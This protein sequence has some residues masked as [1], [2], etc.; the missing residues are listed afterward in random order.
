MALSVTAAWDDNGTMEFA[1]SFIVAT[2][3]TFFMYGYTAL[4]EKRTKNPQWNLLMQ[5][6]SLIPWI[7][8]AGIQQYF[9]YLWTAGLLFGII[10]SALTPYWD[11]INA[12]VNI[13]HWVERQGLFFIIVLGEAV[14]SLLNDVPTG[15]H[16]EVYMSVAMGLIVCF[17]LKWIYFE[18]QG[19]AK[20]I[21]AMN[22]SRTF[23]ALWTF[24]HWPLTIAITALGAGTIGIQTQLVPAISSDDTDCTTS[25]PTLIQSNMTIN[26]TSLESEPVLYGLLKSSQW[27]FSVSL[28]I[29]LFLLAFHGLLSKE[30]NIYLV[31][32]W[33]R[34]LLRAL[35]GIVIMVLPNLALFG[36]R[37]SG[38]MLLGT[39]S[40]IVLF[41][42]IIEVVGILPAK[43][44]D[45][46]EEVQ[47]NKTLA[48]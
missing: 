35:C 23:S 20:Q 16:W 41:L 9:Y 31:P 47:E 18:G 44:E 21:H 48:I 42:A 33:A 10:A 5:F 43:K 25:I 13:E 38:L 17:G 1:I 8:S 11:P 19:M 27:L 32:H 7:V 12:P 3:P 45:E 26:G 22:R 34:V 37:I 29:S 36:T 6:I 46:L 40:A 39:V 14:E 28:G 30:Y 24:S 15:V 2:L 4:S